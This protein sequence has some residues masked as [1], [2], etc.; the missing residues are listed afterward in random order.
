MNQVKKKQHFVPQCYLRNFVG[1]DKK[2]FVWDKIK[3]S[4]YPADVKDVAQDR[5]FNDFPDSFLPEELRDKTKSQ[6]I[7]DDLSK[8]ESS[9]GEFLKSIIDCLEEIEKK[10]LF[11]S[12]GVLDKEAK[13]NFSA[14]LA[15]QLVR[16]TMLRG[17][18][19]GMFQSLDDLKKRMDQALFKNKINIPKISFPCPKNLSNSIDF[20]DLIKVGIEEDSIAQHLIYISNIIDQG[21]DSEIS[22]I[23]SSHIWLFGVNSTSISLW[24]SDNPIAIKSHEDFGTGLSSHGVQVVYPISS[25]HIL[26]MFEPSFWNK[27]KSFDGMSVTLSE[28]DIK[29]YNK[30]Q[31]IQ[32]YRQ[33][34]SSKKNFELLL[35]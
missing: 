15:L 32:C 21:S 7:E 22:K 13:K 10:N 19:R 24:T 17:Q 23:L 18:I 11:D 25:K 34:Y 30:L 8:V 12:L 28:E 26:I 29:S 31:E 1:E 16:T 20:H 3:K 9:F 2:L 5:Y 35:T 6:F 33:T 27:L 4:I 14:F